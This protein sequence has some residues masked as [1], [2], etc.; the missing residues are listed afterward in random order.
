MYSQFYLLFCTFKYLIFNYLLYKI[1][2]NN[3]NNN[4]ENEV[5]Y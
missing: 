4:Q 3:N 2:S 5:S 1:K